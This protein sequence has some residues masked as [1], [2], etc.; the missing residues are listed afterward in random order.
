[1]YKKLS[2]FHYY[3]GKGEGQTPTA[4]VN[5]LAFFVYLFLVFLSVSGIYLMYYGADMG[6]DMEMDVDQ[7][8]KFVT[9]LVHITTMALCVP[10]IYILMRMNN[11]LSHIDETP[12]KVENFILSRMRIPTFIM[13]LIL[14]G[15][16]MVLLN[17]G[18]IDMGNI[19]LSIPLF[20]ISIFVVRNIND[21]ILNYGN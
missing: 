19:I 11:I 10:F 18:K 21:K 12:D 17:Y 15:S 14:M 3:F 4:Y 13:G 2:P 7:H 8:I 1:M 5:F 20:Y 6:V 9:N 16:A